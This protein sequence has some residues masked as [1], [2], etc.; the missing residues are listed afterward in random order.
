MQREN[1]ASGPLKA[2]VSRFDTQSGVRHSIAS[3]SSGR[4]SKNE[5]PTSLQHPLT[6]VQ[7]GVDYALPMLFQ[8]Y[9]K[10]PK[11]CA[12]DIFGYFAPALCPWQERQGTN[13]PCHLRPAL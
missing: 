1:A 3:A 4:A 2:V 11:L 8:S 10:P 7:F 12:N 5:R 9:E 13:S 6:Q